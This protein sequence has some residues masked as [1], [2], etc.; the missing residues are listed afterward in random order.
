MSIN[1]YKAEAQKAAQE[2][3]NRYDLESGNDRTVADVLKI[4]AAHDLLSFGFSRP[5][6]TGP[7]PGDMRKACVVMNELASQSG[8]LATIYMVNGLLAPL[9][10]SYG[11]TTDQK[12]EFLPKVAKGE[13]QLAFA[14]TEPGAGSDAAGIVTTALPCGNQSY[15]LNGEKI[16]ITGAATADVLLTV[17]KTS[18]DNP[19]AFGIVMVPKDTANLKIEPLPKIAGNV[20]PSC[21]VTYDKV[22]VDAGN[23]LG[24][25]NALEAAWSV[26]RNTGTLE[27]LVVAAM[28]CGL[29]RAATDRAAEFIKERQQFGRP[30]KDFQAIQH[31]VVEMATLTK[32]MELFLENAVQAQAESKDP[33][34]AISMA[35]YFCS[36]QAQHV[37]GIAVRVIGGRSYFDFEPVSRLHREAPFCLFAGGTVEIQKMLIARTLGI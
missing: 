14:L 11:G 9:C 36:E 31:A 17:A 12:S 28:A 4:L 34:E 19:K 13:L 27:R 29:A 7:Q 20:I 33:T 22:A 2:A 8:A 25:A 32:S 30:L 24:G 6:N 35:K 23:I 18:P 1:E 15:V 5:G 37:V 16:Y 3:S 21:K 26:L 10:V